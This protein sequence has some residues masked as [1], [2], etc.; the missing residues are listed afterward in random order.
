[1][2]PFCSYMVV[3]RFL[4][5]IYSMKQERLNG[6]LLSTETQLVTQL[7]TKYDADQNFL[8]KKSFRIEMIL[9]TII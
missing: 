6:C 5:R 2:V 9:V 1:M 7:V 3:L 4:I 8:F